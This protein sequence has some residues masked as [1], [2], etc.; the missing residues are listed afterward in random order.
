MFAVLFFGI[1]A[2]AQVKFCPKGA[3]W[4][5]S[6][7]LIPAFNGIYNYANE[8][9]VYVADTIIGGDSIKFLAHTFYYSTC[10]THNTW[11]LKK[12]QIK[13]KGDTVFFKNARTQNTWQILYNYAATAGNGWTTTILKANDT[14]TTITTVVDSVKMVTING[15]NLKR[16]YLKYGYVTE[17]FGFSGF[18]F[19][20]P[21]YAMGCDGY[22]FVE[23]LCY[24]DHEFGEIKF[25]EKSCGYSGSFNINGLGRQV[26][27]TAVKL[28][29]NPVGE[30]IHIEFDEGITHTNELRIINAIGQTQIFLNMAQATERVDV[31]QLPPGI[32]FIEI[33]GIGTEKSYFRFLKE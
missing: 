14:P 18:L 6:F 28:W 9:I 20:F 17:R 26:N 31:S 3:H 10:Y 12:T 27:G 15:F 1:N 30:Y 16:L 13:Q 19:N 33:A 7:L 22:G 5:S 21:S 24:S 23:P 32:Y 25:S 29:P 11:A 4:N 2:G 8:S